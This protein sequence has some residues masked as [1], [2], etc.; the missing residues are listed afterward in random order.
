MKPQHNGDTPG[1]LG[2]G[3]C[4]DRIQAFLRFLVDVLLRVQHCH[5]GSYIGVFRG[6]LKPGKNKVSLKRRNG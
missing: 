4:L 3:N 1:V 6:D 2:Y 5:Q